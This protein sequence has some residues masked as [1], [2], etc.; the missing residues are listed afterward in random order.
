MIDNVQSD[1]DLRNVE[2]KVLAHMQKQGVEKDKAKY[3][4]GI[5]KLISEGVLKPEDVMDLGKISAAM[6]KSKTLSESDK[7]FLSSYPAANTTPATTMAQTNQRGNL[8]IQAGQERNLQPVIDTADSNRLV[9]RNAEDINNENRIHPG[10]YAPAGPGIPTMQRGAQFRAL[11]SSIALARESV[12]NLPNWD[13]GTRAQLA[14]MMASDDPGTIREWLR[15]SVGS[16]MTDKQ[17]EAVQN[18]AILSEDALSLRNLMGLGQGSD[19]VRKAVGGLLPSGKTPDKKYAL[20][21]LDRFERLRSQLEQGN[22]TLGGNQPSVQQQLN[23]PQRPQIN[24]T[25]PDWMKK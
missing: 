6:G 3:T 1:T 9:L 17:K 19:M 10:R 14:N 18:L 4:T 7:G 16:T 20:D 21:Q 8:L 23:L 25:V 24:I 11:K 13:A 22:P 15:G 12:A 5:E 2:D